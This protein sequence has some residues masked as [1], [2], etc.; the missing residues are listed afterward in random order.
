MSIESFRN[1]NTF[2]TN[3]VAG[4]HQHLTFKALLVVL[5]AA[6]QYRT[7][8]KHE[9]APQISQY[10][11][12]Y[13][14][15]HDG[16]TKVKV[17]GVTKNRCQLMGTMSIP[18]TLHGSLVAVILGLPAQGEKFFLIC[19]LLDM[20]WI[21]LF[22]SPSDLSHCVANLDGSVVVSKA[23]HTTCC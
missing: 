19:S 21:T 14:F 18:G 23:L 16:G 13:K 10:F 3:T 11:L 20:D 1:Y 6:V 17:R 12:M 5:Q 15:Q 2:S 7:T 8:M 22:R 9:W 4:K